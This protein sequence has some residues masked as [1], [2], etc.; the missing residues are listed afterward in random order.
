MIYG[1]KHVVFEQVGV[2]NSY[3]IWNSQ[4]NTD[5]DGCCNNYEI[6]EIRNSLSQ[7]ILPKLSNDLTGQLVSTTVQTAKNGNSST[8][9]STDDKL[10][11]S[12]GKEI[13]YS[14]KTRTEENSVLT[15]WQYWSSHTT[16]NDHIKYITGSSSA[17]F[18]CLRSPSKTSAKNIIFCLRTGSDDWN[19]SS[20][21]YHCS[22]CFAW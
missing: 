4:S 13:G 11:I 18:W 6:S 9:V 1:N 5:G 3:Y 22:P 10:F 2:D 19:L 14:S 20:N 8:L 7:T 21:T 12:A 16:A 15:T 17:E